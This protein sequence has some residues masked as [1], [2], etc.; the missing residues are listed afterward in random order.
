MFIVGKQH[1]IKG[2]NKQAQ[3][4]FPDERKYSYVDEDD[5]TKVT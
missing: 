3:N 4:M 1:F 5:L 2:R